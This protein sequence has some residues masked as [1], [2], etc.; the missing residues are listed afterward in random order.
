MKIL[1]R[2]FEIEDAMV[3]YDNTSLHLYRFSYGIDAF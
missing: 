3:A 1:K 2:N